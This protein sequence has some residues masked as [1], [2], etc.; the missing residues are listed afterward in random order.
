MASNPVWPFTPSQ[1]VEGYIN[2]PTWTDEPASANR[3]HPCGYWPIIP[4]PTEPILKDYG[5]LYAAG[6]NGDFQLGFGSAYPYQTIF[7]QSDT[8]DLFTKTQVSYENTFALTESGTLWCVGGN[9]KGQLGLGDNVTRE[10]WTQVPGEWIDFACSPY[11]YFTLAVKSDGTLW[12]SG[13]N[14]YGQLGLGDEVD[15][16][17]FTQVGTSNAWAK[18]ACGSFYSMAIKVDG[19][20]HATGNGNAGATGLGY[21]NGKEDTFTHVSSVTKVEKVTCGYYS[22]AV[23]RE[24]GSLWVT[25]GNFNGQQGMGDKLSRSIFTKVESAGSGILDL[26]MGSNSNHISGGV[27]FIIKSDRTLWAAGSNL[28]NIMGIAD[29]SDKLTFTQL[30]G[31]G[32]L[33]VNS[34]NNSVLG[35]RE[36]G[37]LWGCGKNSLGELGLGDQDPRTEWEHVGVSF[38]LYISCGNSASMGVQW[39]G[40]YIW[41]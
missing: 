19:S 23:I 12:A 17:V 27:L 4:T 18:V 29:T 30:V 24:G 33:V 37:S 10:V 1:G 7:L 8:T 25:G 41:Q 14:N 36:G 31:T 34:K 13:H 3:H 40:E 26:C 16:N 6:D 39:D 21:G 38:W 5:P 20:L 35:V 2:N 22:T 11:V 15:R 9:S 32:W 28:N